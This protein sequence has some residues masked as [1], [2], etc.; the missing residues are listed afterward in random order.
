MDEFGGDEQEDFG[1]YNPL[2]GISERTKE[3]IRKA[4]EEPRFDP[5]S[6][7]PYEF[8]PPAPGPL[9][10]LIDTVSPWAEY[11]GEHLDV[12]DLGPGRHAVGWR[13]FF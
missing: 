7:E 11:I 5:P 2:P 1:S 12:P 9:R 3:I 4:M 8:P 6:P 13:F 10:R